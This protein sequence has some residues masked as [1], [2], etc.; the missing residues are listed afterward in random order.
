MSKKQKLELKEDALRLGENSEEY[1]FPFAD[2]ELGLGHN[3]PASKKRDR[4]SSGPIGIEPP[5]I[6]RQKIDDWR[7]GDCLKIFNRP[8]DTDEEARTRRM[9]V[10][11]LGLNIEQ[12]YHFV[13]KLNDIAIV[14]TENDVKKE[15]WLPVS[16]FIKVNNR[17]C[18]DRNTPN[19]L[20]SKG[21]SLN[22]AAMVDPS[23]APEVFKS[24]QKSDLEFTKRRSCKEEEQF[25]VVN[26]TGI[27]T[28]VENAQY[29]KFA[30]P[31]SG[32]K[33][34]NPHAQFIIPVGTPV[35]LITCLQGRD[36][37]VRNNGFPTFVFSIPIDHL[38][39]S[40]EGEFFQSYLSQGRVSALPKTIIPDCVE[41]NFVLFC[42][43]GL[44]TFYYFKVF[45]G[46]DVPHFTDINNTYTY[47]TNCL[48]KY[49][50][51]N[52]PDSPIKTLS[53][54]KYWCSGPP[55]YR[56]GL[57]LLF[58]LVLKYHIERY[59]QVELIA[60]PFLTQ[61]RP[62]SETIND[63]QLSLIG[64]Y[65]KNGFEIKYNT[66]PDNV[67]NNSL[68]GSIERVLKSIITIIMMMDCE[69]FNTYF[70]HYAGFIPCDCGHDVARAVNPAKAA[71]KALKAVNPVAKKAA[72]KA[73][74][75][76][77]EET[78]A[79]IAAEKGGSKRRTKKRKSK[80]RIRRKSI[81][82]KRMGRT[83]KRRKS[84]KKRK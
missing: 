23:L 46:A 41:Q 79:M 64:N 10:K 58:N 44:L 71:L 47:T 5:P 45:L 83:K 66:G 27:K 13:D 31:I 24:N 49:S 76:V 9:V 48:I 70:S 73:A 38:V 55:G 67:F 77:A 6:S 14:E 19:I 82:K 21:M 72:K 2:E 59:T 30:I 3:P 11:S 81:K 12:L 32:I 28:I 61:T 43:V 25:Y 53:I 37:L 39:A 75:I 33:E 20:Y 57:L 35:T 56:A 54:D 7:P 18:S 17:I 15:F 22:K 51:F 60:Q 84:I 80:K 78:A 40:S 42:Q 69:N 52:E 63:S 8:N 16:Y 29:N 36:V 50:P 68:S 34:P 62:S 1:E 74:K 26:N 65:I 4:D